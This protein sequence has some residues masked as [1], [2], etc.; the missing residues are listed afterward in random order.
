MNFQQTA[1]NQSQ[2]GYPGKNGRMPNVMVLFFCQT[3]A[4]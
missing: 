2:T 4:I 3:E 1:Q